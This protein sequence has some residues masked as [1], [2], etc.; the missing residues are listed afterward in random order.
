LL[1][2]ATVQRFDQDFPDAQTILA[3]ANYRS[4]PDI[5]DAAMASSIVP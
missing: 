1:T 4:P 5:L 3:G 2:G